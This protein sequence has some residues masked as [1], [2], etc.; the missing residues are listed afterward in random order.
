MINSF[1][2]FFASVSF[3]LCEIPSKGKFVIMKFHDS[4]CNSVIDVKLNQPTSPCWST[5]YNNGI[6]PVAY[7]ETTAEM[8]AKFYTT[9]NCYSSDVEEVLFKCD[10]S[11]F[12]NP[13]TN[14]YLK[15]SYV[16]FPSHANFTFN[17][18]LDSEC[19]YQTEINVLKG[20][21]HCW[22][23]HEGL[24][25]T[26]TSFNADNYKDVSVYSYHTNGDC[27]GEYL[28]TPQTIECNNR[29]FKINGDDIFYYRCTYI[30]GEHIKLNSLMIM[31]G[32]LLIL[33]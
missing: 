31:L 7:N 11:C 2:I 4:Q 12:K 15:C 18:Y 6:K 29:C 19:Q 30:A 28:S 20:N 26:P 5:A 8:T 1:F 14:N 32:I 27:L 24:S 10:N 17:T 21:S 13:K 9:S 22:K 25:L 23:I 16:S 33:I 3:I